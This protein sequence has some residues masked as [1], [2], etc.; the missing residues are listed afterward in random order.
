V[1]VRIAAYFAAL[2]QV[3][4]AVEGIRGTDMGS[5]GGGRGGGGAAAAPPTQVRMGGGV[6]ATATAPPI[7]VSKGGGAPATQPAAPTATTYQTTTQ[8]QGDTYVSVQALTASQAAQ[9]MKEISKVL[10]SGERAVKRQLTSSER[11]KV[12]SI[13]ARTT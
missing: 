6:A 8:K 1:W 13:R 11:T 3:W 7:Q 12:G 9:A 10:P 4:Q 5:S 2:A